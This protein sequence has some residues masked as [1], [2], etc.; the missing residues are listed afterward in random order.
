MPDK[1]SWNSSESP[2]EHLQ[3][4]DKSENDKREFRAIRLP[5]GLEALLI[6]DKYLTSTSRKKKAACSL[7]VNVGNF[8]NLPQFPNISYF[9]ALGYRFFQIPEKCSEQRITFEKFI[10]DHHGTT[11]FSIENE[12]TRY[13]F[14]I[15][16]NNLF[17]AL[18]NFRLFFINPI[19]PKHRFIEQLNAIKTAFQMG[20][21][22]NGKSKYEQLF[23]SFAQT[24]HPANMFSVDDFKKF[25]NS[26]DYEKL[27]NVLDTFKKRHYS[28]HRMK[29]A[30]RSG[31]SLDAMEKFVKASFARVPNN[32]MPPDNFSKFK[33]DLPFDTSAFRRMY[34]IHDK[35][36]LL[37]QLQI[38]WALPSFS[39]YYKCNSYQYIPL[40]IGYKGKGSLIKYLQKKT[41][42]STLD[43]NMSVMYCKIQPNSLYTLLRLTMTLTFEGRKHLENVLDAIF[44]FINLLK[45]VD[46]QKEIYNDI[47]KIKQN[48]FRYADYDEIGIFEVKQLSM[49]MHFYPP[50]AY[51]TINQFDSNYNAQVI[52]KCLNYLAPEMAN[53]MI[54]SNFSSSELNKVEPW[55]QTAY[56]DIEIPKEWIERWKII[57]PLPEFHL[58]LPNIFLANN[59][60]LLKTPNETI[61]KYPVKLY[62]NSMS[63]LWYR[64]DFKRC[65]PKCYM[66]FYFISPLKLQSSK[67]EALMDMYC[68][69]LEQLLADELY[70]A[71]QVGFK[72]NISVNTNGFTLKI[73]GLNETLP[74]ITLENFQDFVK[75]FTER[76]YI[77]CLVQGNMTSTVAIKTLQQ[78][79]KTINCR[80]LHSDTIQLRSTQ[81]PLGTSYYKIKNINKVDTISM[82]SNYYQTG[83]NTIELST[84]IHLI[85]YIMKFKLCEVLPTEKFGS[86]T[87]DVTDVNGILGYFITIRVRAD[88]YTTEYIDKRID[89]FLRW[90]KNVLEMFTEKE[91]DVYKEMFLKSKSHD[92]NHKA[93]LEDEVERNW[94]VIVKCTYIFDFH[95]QEILALKKINVNKLKEWSADHISDESNFRKLSLHIVKSQKEAEYVHL[96]HINDDYQQY[97]PNH[98][99]KNHYITNVED[100]KKKLVIFPTKRSNK[101]F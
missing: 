91:L 18:H 99:I 92:L 16:E 42:S 86:T 87:V 83:I 40:I 88:R 79:I 66:H 90:F 23:F 100:Y 24:G 59:S 44:S 35:T 84:L 30:I 10:Q 14:D 51:I 22:F 43:N 21:V 98:Y 48:I 56:T 32:R 13:Y 2:V 29:L 70:P 89:Q 55:W 65:L 67:N 46:Q 26:I 20:T 58:P 34:T 50:K 9:L 54:F 76:L 7:C 74:D 61:E 37:T 45:T 1:N 95:E 41:W 4:P 53:I 11:D 6:S 101:S 63:E 49:N 97:K 38:T 47:I 94:E 71:L 36:K 78:Y 68:I 72:Y 96:E 27:Y 15:E 5:N 64:P 85:I 12:H 52:Q 28:A 17:L 81:I 25:W 62:S 19:L 80:P 93:N 57:E 60:Y 8:S 75:S 33:N 73:S 77:Q 69:L 31:L 82:V 3:Q 39:D